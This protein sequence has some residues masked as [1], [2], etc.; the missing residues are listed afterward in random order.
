MKKVIPALLILS[1][2]FIL[3][4][5]Q[6]NGVTIAVIPKGT[7][8][9]FWKAV[10]SGAEK[11]G[12]EEGI[13]I[14]WNGPAREGDRD[15]QIQVVEDFMTRKVS[16]MVLAPL[17]SKALAPV[18]EKVS[19]AGIPCAII[20]SSV[21]TDGYLSFIATDNYLGG[22]L[23]ARHLIKKLGGKGKVGLIQY[24]AGS[25]STT[26]RENG[27]IETI[28]KEGGAIK[29][30]DKKYGL[31]TVETALQAAEDLLTRNKELDGI[32]AVN[33]STAVGTLRA[34]ESQGRVKKVVF[35]GFDSSEPLVKG[36]ESGNI[37]ALIVQNPFKMG[38]EGVKAVA[39]KLNGKTVAKKMDTGVEL[40][41]RENLASE[42]IQVLLHPK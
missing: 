16:G 13:R 35:L 23:A 18:V 17:D 34:L 6:K 19:K 27:F 31:D 15:G 29:I 40:I 20:D 11:A 12:R 5:C 22:M 26:E 24:M 37:E 25:A 10:K 4:N 39:A 1:I 33:E 41:T 8:H 2:V 21:N 3:A 38:Y 7:S 36:L 14:F 42:K 28:A 9:D 32:F 30:V